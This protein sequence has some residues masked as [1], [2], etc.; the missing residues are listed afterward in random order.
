MCFKMKLFRSI[1]YSFGFIV[2]TVLSFIMS[3]I[4]WPL[5]RN[6]RYALLQFWAIFNIFW[7]KKTCSIEHRVHGLE[8]IPHDRPFVIISN[9]QS[10]WETIAFQRIFPNH[11]Y[12]IKKELLWIP[13]FGLPL[14]LMSPIV[15]DRNKPRKAGQKIISMGK[16][17]LDNNVSVVIFPEG[18][19]SIKNARSRYSIGG[20]LLAQKSG[21]DVLPVMHN[22][23]SCWS[24]GIFI[25]T[26]GI[27]NVHI[28]EPIPTKTK[29]A[30]QVNNLVEKWADK[31][32]TLLNSDNN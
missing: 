13:F 21:Y 20:A 12:V 17:S 16:Q 5:A 22:S 32:L 18:S 29:T 8:N 31:Q 2:I 1:L 11:I 4:I 7:L 28:G 23:G 24:K 15:I 10:T 25:K 14:K 19:R 3:L 6:R 27:I 30:K 26:A 9:H